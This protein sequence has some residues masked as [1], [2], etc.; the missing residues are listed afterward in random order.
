MKPQIS[1][2]I[3]WPWYKE[4]KGER[5]QRRIPAPLFGVEEGGV[6][7][8][9]DEHKILGSAQNRAEGRSCLGFE[10]K[11]FAEKTSLVL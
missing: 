8:R 4:K 11:K 7:Y 5:V 9:I 1:A 3:C 6:G 2:S 10:K